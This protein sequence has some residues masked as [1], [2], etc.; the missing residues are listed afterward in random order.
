ME[1]AACDM[2]KA[3][4]FDAPSF[5]VAHADVKAL[6]QDEGVLPEMIESYA[7]RFQ[8]SIYFCG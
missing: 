8:M 2:A 7:G 4:G 6:K 1:V 5:I 3:L